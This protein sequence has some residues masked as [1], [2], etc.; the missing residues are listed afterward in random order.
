MLSDDSS[1]IDWVLRECA[2]I[3]VD[4][5]DPELA[6]LAVAIH[7]EDALELSVPPEMLNADHLLPPAALER[8]LRHLLG[9]P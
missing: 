5:T 3:P 8:T 1:R 6:A 4:S 7:V 9:E 2:E